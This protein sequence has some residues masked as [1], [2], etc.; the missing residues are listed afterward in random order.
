MKRKTL[1]SLVLVVAMMITSLPAF[2]V[3]AD[4]NVNATGAVSSL[5]V[6]VD[7]SASKYFPAIKNQGDIG[8]CGTW[9]DVYY[10]FSYA[11]C[12]DNDLE[13]TPDNCMSPAFVYGNTK[14][15][16]GGQYGYTTLSSVMSSMYSYGTVSFDKVD[17]ASYTDESAVV[18]MYPQEELW[19]EALDKRI[20]TYTYRNIYG[21]IQDTIDEIKGYL[22]DGRLV[23][24][25]TDYNGWNYETVSSDSKF[26]GE[27]IATYGVYTNCGHRMTIVGY[28]D[29]IF[30]DINKDGV[31]E[32]AER[33]AFKV[34]NSYGTE[35]G[36]DGFIWLSY[37][38]LYRDS[39]V[40]V[41]PE[42]R[43]RTVAEIGVIKETGRTNSGL[44]L[45]VTLNSANAYENKVT[46]K[47]TNK[48]TGDTVSST[49]LSL[50]SHQNGYA[51]DGSKYATDGTLVF[52]LSTCLY[53]I[54]KDNYDQ[55]DWSIEM[56]DAF[57][58]NNSS[59]LKN[60]KIEVDNEEVLSIDADGKAVNGSN[61]KY[62]F[63]V[64]S[65]NQVVVYYKN[66]SFAQ[67]N[68]HY[69]KA[70]GTWTSVP[71]VRMSV[72]D[73][74]D[75]DYMYV[76]DLGNRTSTQVCFNNGNG[77]WD[78]CNGL[79][80]TVSAGKY[81]IKD[82][83]AKELKEV[84]SNKV[85]IYYNNSNFAQ[86]NIHYQAGN[87]AWTSAPG[88]TMQSSDSPRYT[89]MYVIDL[90]EETSANICFNDGN[91]NWDSKNGSNYH[92]GTGTFAVIYGSVY[93]LSD[94]VW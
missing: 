74:A 51:L 61:V 10:A 26:A 42:G 78:S 72:S 24:Y 31:I 18:S 86:A 82:G 22:Y 27:Q 37:D 94:V 93:Y 56:V 29:E 71:G 45:V 4:A 81:G 1:V 44:D 84:V 40:G 13:A 77:N 48:T 16:A 32:D 3:N 5:P 55:Y 68:I 87:G 54:N 28:D 12:R 80:Y 35:Y 65:D 7:N 89:W 90:G 25:T 38:S 15:L 33:G 43:T 53:G 75:Y 2:A 91:G 23:T 21:N 83:Q 85:K 64:K 60:A 57:T 34:A 70:D 69:V 73:R 9:A 19:K 8:S 41:Q 49:V 92:V 62:D 76:I 67:A 6:S 58:D 59:V 47:A 63:V 52:D 39:L 17:F 11:Y 46:V 14:Q 79:N 50:C 36:N 30:V 20:K 88:V 66:N